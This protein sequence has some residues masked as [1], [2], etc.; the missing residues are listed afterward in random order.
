MIESWITRIGVGVGIVLAL[1]YVIHALVRKRKP[2]LPVAMTCLLTGGGFV[3]GPVLVYGAFDGEIAKQSLKPEHLAIAGLA[4]LWV[5]VQ[6]VLSLRQSSNPA[7][8]QTP[9]GSVSPQVCGQTTGGQGSLSE[10]PTLPT[11]TSELPVPTGSP[12]R[13]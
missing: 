1:A 10:I 8:M 5:S 11:A 3:V 6:F 7:A 2:E 4:I 12:N 9:E 13:S